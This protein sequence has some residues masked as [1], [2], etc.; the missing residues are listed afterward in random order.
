MG[1]LLTDYHGIEALGI[2]L[3]LNVLSM[4]G[5]FLFKLFDK[6]NDQ[7]DLKQKAISDKTQDLSVKMATMSGSMEH[8]SNTMVHLQN[9]ISSYM[10]TTI[11]FASK[12]GAVE[13]Q[14]VNSVENLTELEKQI[15]KIARYDDDMRKFMHAIKWIAGPERWEEIKETILKDDFRS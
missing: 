5:K 15:S 2:L 7:T 4:V 6:R 10:E 1:H 8:I 9:L 12:L 3:V 11:G 14:L 13:K